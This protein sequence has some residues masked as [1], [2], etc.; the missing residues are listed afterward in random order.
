MVGVFPPSQGKFNRAEWDVELVPR[1]AGT[2]VVQHFRYIPQTA[3]AWQMLA[4]LGDA[5]GIAE[6]CQVNLKLLKQRLE[7]IKPRSIGF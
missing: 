3:V 1:D 7:R 5:D 4:A 2:R 6:V